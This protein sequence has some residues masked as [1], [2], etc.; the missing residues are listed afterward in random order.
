MLICDD[1]QLL[2]PLLKYVSS[3]TI[4]IPIPNAQ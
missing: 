4:P 2:K 1:N 3:F